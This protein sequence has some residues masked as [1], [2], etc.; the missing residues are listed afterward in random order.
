MKED[1]YRAESFER[2]KL[3]SIEEAK[4]EGMSATCSLVDSGLQ[5]GPTELCPV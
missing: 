3:A 2:F 5:K 4:H 1:K